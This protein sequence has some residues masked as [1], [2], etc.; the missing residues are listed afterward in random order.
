MSIASS[1]EPRTTIQERMDNDDWLNDAKAENLDAYR[2]ARNSI[3]E[4]LLNSEGCLRGEDF[5]VVVAMAEA[6][7]NYDNKLQEWMGE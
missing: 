6:F 4:R 2:E 5:R 3:P 1:I 7:L